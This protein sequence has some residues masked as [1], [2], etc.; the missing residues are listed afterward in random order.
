[1]VLVKIFGKGN[2]VGFR[3]WI[4]VNLFIYIV[5]KFKCIYLGNILLWGS[6]FLLWIVKGLVGEIKYDE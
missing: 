6:C 4:G 5:G 2:V 3:S 1:M